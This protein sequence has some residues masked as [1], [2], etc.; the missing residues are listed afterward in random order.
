[1]CSSW[2]ASGSA[3]I[4]YASYILFFA[5]TLFS[6][7]ARDHRET[8]FTKEEIHIL[9]FFYDLIA[10]SWFRL[11]LSALR[12]ATF[13]VKS[14]RMHFSCCYKCYCCCF[15]SGCTVEILENKSIGNV[16]FGC[17]IIFVVKNLWTSRTSI[18]RSYALCT[19]LVYGVNAVLLFV[20]ATAAHSI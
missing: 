2:R 16:S 19:Q 18:I 4:F 12:F 8:I 9:P 13:T 14:N 6:I 1:M 5:F 10:S 7:I 20:V 15:M 3:E 17:C 11:L